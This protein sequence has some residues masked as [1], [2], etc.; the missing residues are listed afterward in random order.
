MF[1]DQASC[2]SIIVECIRLHWLVGAFLCH[3]HRENG[4]Q[5][6]IVSRLDSLSLP[7]V[8]LLAVHGV[9]WG[10]ALCISYMF[11][12]LCNSLRDDSCHNKHNRAL[13]PIRRTSFVP[14]SF[15]CGHHNLPSYV[16]FR[17]GDIFMR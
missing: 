3:Y 12:F 2:A 16:T 6:D 10:V 13:S 11:S 1:S 8:S 5:E 15:S 7:L 14:L 17:M 4:L 9:E